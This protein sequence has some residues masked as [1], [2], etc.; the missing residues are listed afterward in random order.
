MNL[1]WRFTVTG[2]FVVLK[3]EFVVVT[4]FFTSVN[5][6]FRINKYLLLTVHAYNLGVTIRLHKPNVFYKRPPGI[7]K[8]NYPFILCNYLT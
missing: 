1:L 4:Y 7:H 6:P 8:T 2:D 3:R 5:M